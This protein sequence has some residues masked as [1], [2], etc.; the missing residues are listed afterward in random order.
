M[1]PI[2]GRRAMRETK[3]KLLFSNGELE[4]LQFFIGKKDLTVEQ[5]GT[6]EEEAGP[7]QGMNLDK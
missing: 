6:P 3:I 7:S 1:L 5:P 4:A 2:E